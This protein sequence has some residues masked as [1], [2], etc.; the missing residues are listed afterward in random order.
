MS[1][2][3]PLPG[4]TGESRVGRLTEVFESGVTEPLECGL[5]CELST[6]E[7]DILKKTSGEGDLSPGERSLGT[8]LDT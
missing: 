7:E 5:E 8:L 4:K 2:G 6:E 3:E 1:S